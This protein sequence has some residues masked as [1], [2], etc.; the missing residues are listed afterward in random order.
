MTGI[1]RAS[2]RF[3]VDSPEFPPRLDLVAPV[4]GTLGVL[5]AAVDAGGPLPL[6]TLRFLVGAAFYGAVTD[7][8]LLGHWYLVQPGLGAGPAGRARAL[9]RVDLAVRGA[10]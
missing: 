5:A 10:S 4:I 3:D 1:D 7:A 6:A 9:D 8:M 2:Q